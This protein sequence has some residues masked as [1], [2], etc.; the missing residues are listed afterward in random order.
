[1]AMGNET[2]QIIMAV[3]TLVTATF[4]GLAVLFTA[5]VAGRLKMQALVLEQQNVVLTETKKTVELTHEATNSK[6]DRL[7]A[8]TAQA[9][10]ARGLKQGQDEK[11][12]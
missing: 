4:S 8:V 6:M 1:M 7:L 5:L 10:E 11:K 3:G 9:A 2:A 12:V